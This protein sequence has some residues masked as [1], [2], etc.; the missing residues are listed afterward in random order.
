VVSFILAAAV[1]TGWM[2]TAQLVDLAGK[3][4]DYEK[5]I[6]AKLQSFK[7]PAGGRFTRFSQAVEQI[8]KELPGAK[9][10]ETNQNPGAVADSAS[11]VK[12]TDQPPV[13]PAVPVQVVENS[14]TNP[15][16]ILGAIIS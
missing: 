8:K 15:I 16:R 4:P 13:H 2:L 3:L 11:A 12:E 9:A 5:D 10:P 14:H 6:E 7:R 1:G